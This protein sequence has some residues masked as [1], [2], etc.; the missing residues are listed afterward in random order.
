[1]AWIKVGLYHYANRKLPWLIRWYGEIEPKTGKLKR[2]GKSFRTKWQ[3]ED[4]RL[5]KMQEF[6]K[7]IKR[8]RPEEVAL[9]RLCDDFLKTWNPAAKEAT[10]D[11]YRSTVER[12]LSHFGRNCLVRSIGPKEADNFLAEQTHYINEPSKALSD[13]T[14]LQ[15]TRHCKTIFGV[16]LRWKWIALN[17]FAD[18]KMPKPGTKRWHRLAV[19]EY[20]R[21]L[22]VAPTLRWKV[23]YAL[24]F[25]S[26]ARFGELFNLTWA[27]IDFERGRMIIEN[28]EVSDFM[29]PFS[30]KDK[31]E[32]FVQLPTDT[33]DLLTQYQQ[34]AP[35]GVP[36]ILLTKERYERVL[37]RWHMY[38]KEEWSWRNRYMVN[39]VGRDFKSHAKR[40]GL[41]FNGSFTI[42]TFRKTCAQNWADYLPANVV[43]FYLGHSKLETTNRFYSI[44]DESHT[45][46]TKKVMDKMLSGKT[47]NHLDT[48]WTL[49]AKSKKK[50]DIKKGASKT[51]SS[52]TPSHKSIS[53][54]SRQWA[55]LDLNQ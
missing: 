28:R 26:G 21:L 34:E 53:D 50:L 1:M 24:V 15:I 5:E 2:Y 7:G 36:Y 16:A 14:R 31:E 46:W 33:L 29:P 47:Q 20:R 18:V 22:E 32:R 6:K 38:R 23:F 41:R 27:D 48:G 37:K 49:E 13:W 52:V 30:V 11:L 10:M 19:S 51:D 55:V 17:P 8:D 45:A 3:A 43:K 54:S 42:H 39:N 35:E 44:V 40:A 12:L 25:T 4:F 9:G